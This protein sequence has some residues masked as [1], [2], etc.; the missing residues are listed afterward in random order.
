MSS[1]RSDD[2]KNWRGIN[3]MASTDATNIAMVTPIVTHFSFIA[4]ERKSR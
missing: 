2:G 3:G 4:I 1:V